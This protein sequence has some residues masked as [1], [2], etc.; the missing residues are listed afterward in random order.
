MCIKKKKFEGGEEF[1]KRKGKRGDGRKEG[2]R[3]K[4][5]KEKCGKGIKE[6]KLF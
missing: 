5:G 3:E 1:L 2:K 6:G 4:R